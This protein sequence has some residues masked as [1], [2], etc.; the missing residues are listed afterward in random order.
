MNFLIKEKFLIKMPFSTEHLDTNI[1][2]S[3]FFFSSEV[4]K[5]QKHLEVNQTYRFLL[6]CVTR[7]LA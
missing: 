7:K 1:M 3:L 2:P 5:I 4:L 6:A